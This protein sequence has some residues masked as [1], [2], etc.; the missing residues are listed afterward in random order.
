M[1]DLILHM[2]ER[3]FAFTWGVF[4]KTRVGAALGK[5]TSPPR[6]TPLKLSE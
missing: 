2:P 6:Q 1:P 4:R 3:T 5:K